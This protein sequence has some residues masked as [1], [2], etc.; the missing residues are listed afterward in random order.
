MDRQRAYEALSIAETATDAGLMA[1]WL[2]VAVV[3]ALLAIATAIQ[4]RH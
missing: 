2:G 4:E 3:T 1:Y